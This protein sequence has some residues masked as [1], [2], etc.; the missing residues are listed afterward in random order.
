MAS[1][2]S[3]EHASYVEPEPV[4]SEMIDATISSL[5][6]SS[7]CLSQM[8]HVRLYYVATDE[9]GIA[10]DDGLQ[11]RTSLSTALA[12]KA[13]SEGNNSKVAGLPAISVV[14][15]RG[16]KFV[17][18]VDLVGT[19]FVA[20]QVLAIDPIHMETELWIHHAREEN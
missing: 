16:I 9:S 15:V 8:L 10:S 2:T 12:L 6:E 20:I 3:G 4:L 17:C 19:P 14:P 13:G 1:N 18:D 5:E 7:L 11:W